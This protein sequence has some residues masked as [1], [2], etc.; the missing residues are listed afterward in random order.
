MGVN[1]MAAE[2]THPSAKL[3]DGSPAHRWFLGVP[4]TPLGL[5][6]AAA[7]IADRPP[8]ARFAFVTTPN[9][10]HTVH[11]ARGDQR[12]AV[13]HD[14]AW[15][16]LNDSR[17]LRLLSRWLFGQD[18]PMTAGSDLTVE[19]FRNYIHA[20]D[21]I[22]IIGG[23][24]EVEDRLRTVHGIRSVAR[25]NPPMGFIDDP[26]EVERC[27]DFIIQHPARYVFLAVGAPQ[28]EVVACRVLERGDAVGTALC[29]GSSLLF[30]TGV[31]R[32]APLI[33]RRLNAEWAYRLMQNPR[34][35]ARRV[36]LDSLPV[37]WL[38]LKAL[39]GRSHERHA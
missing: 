33:I 31:V 36:F 27:V 21:R 13:A 5:A 26:T 37:L 38:A 35:H 23:T 29:I 20:E 30:V 4:F 7:C 19:L 2:L 18:L 1:V 11:C 25:F 28:S 32:R 3:D 12:F 10:H 22:T 6:E 17:I 15:L 8:G 9:A 24:D 16:V 14:A 34:R 39:F